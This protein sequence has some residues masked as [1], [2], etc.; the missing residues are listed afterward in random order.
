[1]RMRNLKKEEMQ[2]RRAL[3]VTWEKAHGQRGRCR[4]RKEKTSL[5]KRPDRATSG[6]QPKK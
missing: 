4:G 5:R 1:M 6:G 2:E 3:T